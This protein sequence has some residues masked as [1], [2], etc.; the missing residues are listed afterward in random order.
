MLAGIIQ[1][2][3]FQEST[4]VGWTDIVG[5]NGPQRLLKEAVVMPLKYPQ[6]FTGLLSPWCGVLLYGPPGNGKTMLAKA[7]ASEC[8]TTFFNISA[9]SIVSKYRYAQCIG[10]GEGDRLTGAAPLRQAHPT[11]QMKK[12]RHKSRPAALHCLFSCRG[13]SE[14]LVRVL[15]EL[16]RHHS[17]S[18]IFIDEID[19]IM[20][21]RGSQGESGGE[22]EGS[23]RMKTELLIQMDGLAKQSNDGSVFV[24]AASNLPWELDVALL[25]RLEKRVMVTMPTLEAREAMIRMHLAGRLHKDV[26]VAAAAGRMTGYSGADVKLVCKEAAM[27]PVRKLMSR[28]EGVGQMTGNNAIDDEPLAMEVTEEHLAAALATTKPSAHKFAGKYTKWGQEY[29]ST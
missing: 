18:T 5:L 28:L 19:S 6:L 29:G 11:T 10:C 12:T 21:Q 24:L 16:A 9:A 4:G 7:V 14:K 25:R 15:F 22:H 8:G 20:G 23:R 3:I 17:P 2:D 26:G 13:D 1:R 27:H